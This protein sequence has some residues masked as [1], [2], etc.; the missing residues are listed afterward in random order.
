MTNFNFSYLLVILAFTMTFF[1]IYGQK[2]ADVMLINNQVID[3]DLY[4]DIKGSPYYFKEW[5]QG[6]VKSKTGK[7]EEEE[8]FLLNLNGYTKNFEIRKDASFIALD[9]QYYKEVNIKNKAGEILTFKTGLHPIY[10][11]RFMRLV[12]TGEG[13][14]IIQEFKV[15]LSTKEK[16]IYAETEIIKTF[17]SKLKYVVIRDGI[18]KPIKL[19][20]KE[21]LKLFNDKEGLLKDYINTKRPKLDKEK[22]LIDVF[23]YYDSLQKEK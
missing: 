1:E 4:K 7:S 9:E 11:S 22:E 13:Y 14:Y 23:K 20:K 17:S 15:H 2:S 8:T 21:L 10:K 3:A 6:T 19:K 18:A 16:E 12:H 5:K